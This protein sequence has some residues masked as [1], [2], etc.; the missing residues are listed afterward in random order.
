[1]ERMIV[2]NATR[3]DVP[4]IAALF[5]ESFKDSVIHHCGVLPKPQAMQD[6]FTLVYQAE[7]A[8]AFVARFDGAIIG[9]CFAPLDLSRLWIRAITG[10]HII[11]WA[12]RW[13]TGRYG[14]GLHPVK[15]IV[16]NK[17]AFL[18]SAVT[19]GKAANARILSVAVAESY[20]GQGVAKALMQAALA[21]FKANKASLIRLEVRPDNTPAVKVYEKLGFVGSGTTRD[22]Q[23]EWLIMFKGME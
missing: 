23:G 13:L 3:E 2:E 11:K 1:M 7:P 16:L 10:G 14:F 12:W 9:Y 4:A 15:I 21:Y 20:R 6:V 8:A 17:I 19:P 5:T 18:T 22:S